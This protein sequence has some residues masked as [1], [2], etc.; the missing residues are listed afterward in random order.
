[1]TN[2]F[3]YIFIS[4]VLLFGVN[5][6]VWACPLRSGIPDT[7]CDGKTILSFFGDSVTRGTKDPLINGVNGG[8]PLRLRRYLI[9]TLELSKKEYKVINFGHPGIKCANLRV[10]MRNRIL[11]NEKNVAN[12]DATVIACGLNDYWSHRNPSL[13]AAYLQA[14]KRFAKKRGIYATVGKVTNT[15]RDFQQPFVNDIN[16]KIKNLGKNLRYDL[17]DPSS[18]LDPDA[19][20]PNGLGYDFMFDILKSYLFGDTFESLAL[21]Q[22]KLTDN[23]ADGLYDSFELSKFGTDPTNPDTDADTINDGDEIFTFGTD[24]LSA[25]SFPTPEPTPEVT[26]SPTPE[27]SPEPSPSPSASPEVSPS[28]SPA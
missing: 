22:L 12:S 4:S 6:A 16:K 27:V 28:P 8:A 21:T 5:A 17:L 14:M 26:P 23:D 11:D 2:K 1:M 24:P 3:K 25:L 15:N 18:M 10:E 13:T 19:I 9:K 7:N 20:H